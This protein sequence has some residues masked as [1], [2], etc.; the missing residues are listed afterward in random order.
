MLDVS[1]RTLRVDAHETFMDCAYYEQL[2]Y[3]GDRG[4]K[5]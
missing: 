4:W 2:Q 3:I 5:L 1:W